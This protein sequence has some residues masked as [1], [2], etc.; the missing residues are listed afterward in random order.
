MVNT[1]SAYTWEIIDTK[2][3]IMLLIEFFILEFISISL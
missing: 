2:V 3:M 1:Q